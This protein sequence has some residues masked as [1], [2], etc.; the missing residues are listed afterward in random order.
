[1]TPPTHL[2]HLLIHL[3]S[4]LDL[5]WSLLWARFSGEELD[6]LDCHPPIY[7]SAGGGWHLLDHQ[8]LHLVLPSPPLSPPLR[9]AQGKGVHLNQRTAPSLCCFGS[10][11][12]PHPCHCSP[13]ADLYPWMGFYLCNSS[14][15]SQARG[16]YQPHVPPSPLLHCFHVWPPSHQCPLHCVT[17]AVFTHDVMYT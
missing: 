8:Q 14:A 11:P 5:S 4:H 3:A 12:S 1:M 2:A 15:S 9:G 7:E 6:L 10:F 17:R 16:Q 13:M